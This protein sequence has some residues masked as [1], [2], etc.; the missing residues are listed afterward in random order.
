M[1]K[2]RRG[3]ASSEDHDPWSGMGTRL[4]L[5]GAVAFGALASGFLMS[6]RGRRLVADTFRGRQ[7]TPLADRVLDLFWGDPM[8]GRRHLDVEER[9]EGIVELLGTVASDRERS[10]AL[11]L[12]ARV[13]GVVELRDHLVLDASIIRRR[14]RSDKDLARNR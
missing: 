5:G 10:L 7:R 11:E 14:A 1:A 8:L 2:L 6:R 12:A 13:P 3:G 4:M 9:E